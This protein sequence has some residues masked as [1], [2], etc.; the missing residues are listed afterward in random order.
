MERPTFAN[1]REAGR[2]LG[3]LVARLPD[4]AD[5]VV[6]GLVRGGVPVAY[7]VAKA[8]SLPLDILVVRKLGVPSQP[9]LAMGAIAG[10]GV[11]VLNEDLLRSCRISGPQLDKVIQ[12]ERTE[13]HRREALYRQGHPAV[14]INSRTVILVDDGLATGASMKVAIRAVKPDARRVIVA[15]PVGARS[16]CDDLYTLA[17]EVVCALVPEPLESVGQFYRNFEATSDEEVRKLLSEGTGRN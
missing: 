1:R 9:E 4:I 5:A 2:I 3:A 11:I 13:L 15:V 17:D 8:C 7:E 14:P 12:Q 16:T 6:L 10:G